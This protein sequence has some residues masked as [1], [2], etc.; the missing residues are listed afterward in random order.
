MTFFKSHEIVLRRLRPYGANFQ[1]Y[2]PTF[3]AYQAD[4][5]P[6]DISR[7]NMAGGRVGA[8][9]DCFVDPTVPIQEGDQVDAGGKRYSVQTV[10]TFEGSG[11]LEHK[12]CILVS[13]DG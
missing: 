1:N 6:M 9:Y 10:N 8:I 2:S 7:A 4:I 5:Q 3:T 11:L 13:Q 12:H